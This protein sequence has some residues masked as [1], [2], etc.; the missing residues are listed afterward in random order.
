[1]LIGALAAFTLVAVMGLAMFLDVWRGK[2][3]EPAYPKLH[4]AAS[5]VGAGLVIW[6]AVEGDMRLYANIGMAVVIILLGLAM[7][8]IAKK[9]KPVPKAI[10]VSHVGL[11]VACY[12]LLGF[13]A[14][15]T[16]VQLF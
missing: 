11:A 13:F 15:N 10:L 1:M 12:L 6:A 7:G 4:A 8:L 9:G 3:I 16:G 2:G 14:L 5:L